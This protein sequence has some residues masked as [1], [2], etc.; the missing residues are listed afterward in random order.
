MRIAV[1]QPNYAPWSGYFAKMFVSDVFVFFDDAQLPGGSSYVSR[2]KIAKGKDSDQWLTVPISKSGLLTPISHVHVATPGFAAKHLSTLLHTY[3]R[4]PHREE[5]LDLLTPVYARAGE[6]LANF[7]MDLIQTVAEYLGW[8]G[9]FVLSSDHPS[10]LKADERLA[11][12]V[13]WLGGDTYVSGAGGEKYQSDQTY[14]NRGV[15][16]EVRKYSPIKYARSGWDWVPGLS[17]VDVLFHQGIAARET[18]TY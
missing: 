12:L 9:K 1:H 3:S 11:D 17:S 14:H 4:T 5:I 13:S 15:E 7:N 2:A 8:Q 6:S 18:M 10:H 16:L